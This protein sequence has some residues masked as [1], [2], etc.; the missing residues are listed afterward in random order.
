MEEIS[1]FETS[2]WEIAA[3]GIGVYVA[4]WLMMRLTPKRQAG[5]LSPNDMIAL[6]VIGSLAANAIAGAVDAL[7]DLLL[8]VLVIVMCDYLLNLVEYY[9]P[10]VHRISQHSPTLLIHDGVLLENNLRKEK[11]TEQELAASLREHG[12]LAMD[13]VQQA[14]LEADGKISIVKKG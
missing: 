2:L 1:L 12:I 7:P 4:L 10:R 9:F 6:V 3:R 5:S 13:E 11:L 8:M 14:V